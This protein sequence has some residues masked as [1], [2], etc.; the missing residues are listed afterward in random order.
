MSKMNMKTIG[1]IGGSTWVSTVDYYRFINEEVNRRLGDK[2][3]AKCIIYSIDFEEIMAKNWNNW[4]EIEKHFI[5]ISKKLE[6]AGAQMLV[7]CANTPH[8]IANKIQNKINIPLIHIADVTAEKIKEA[9]LKKVGL[10]GTIYTMKED[11]IKQ[12]IKDKYGIDVIVPNSEDQK[13]IE[14]I[15]FDELTFEDIQESSKQKYIKIINKLVAAGAEGIILGCTEIPLLI[16]QKDV[17]IPVF[18][19]TEIHAK[20]AVDYALEK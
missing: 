11:F 9:G 16:K 6:N 20:A 19:T 15:I 5:Q 18:N 8:R 4:S 14:N 13:I 17:N 1:L 7:I 3:S 2:H 10:L 12:R